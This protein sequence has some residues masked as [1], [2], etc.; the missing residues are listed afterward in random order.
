MQRC[1]NFHCVFISAY[2]FIQSLVLLSICFFI[3]CP[4]SAGFQTT[5]ASD[6]SALLL[7]SSVQLFPPAATLEASATPISMSH[8]STQSLHLH[9]PQ[10][11]WPSLSPDLI[12]PL[13][14]NWSTLTLSRALHCSSSAL[15]SK[16]ADGF[17]QFNPSPA[18]IRREALVTGWLLIGLGM[19]FWCVDF[20]STFKIE[21]FRPNL[22]TFDWLSRAFVLKVSRFMKPMLVPYRL[23][24]HWTFQFSFPPLP[25][26][27]TAKV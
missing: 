21:C 19:R 27:F 10:Q 24:A 12:F 20:V 22:S 23:D 15:Y 6:S 4:D 18:F 26:H 25:A 11:H 8:L 14:S 3:S 2:V 16:Y 9:L 13:L 7:A 17:L 5:F 1:Q